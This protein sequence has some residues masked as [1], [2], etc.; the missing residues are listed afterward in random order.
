MGCS[1]VQ[2]GVMGCNGMQRGAAGCSGVQRGAVGCSS[3]PPT[4]RKPAC[5]RS[6]HSPSRAAPPA[7]C[8]AHP[9]QVAAP[10]PAPNRSV[11]VPVPVPVPPRPERGRPSPPVLTHG[12]GLA[13]APLPPAG[14]CCGRPAIPAIPAIPVIP[15]IPAEPA[16]PAGLTDV[17]GRAE[18]GLPQSR[19]QLG[20]PGRGEPTGTGTA[21]GSGHWHPSPDPTGPCKTARAS[22]SPLVMPSREGM[23][24]LAAWECGPYIPAAL[25]PP[26]A[27]S[28]LK[29]CQI[30]LGKVAYFTKR[31]DSAL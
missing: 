11:S 30:L 21:S 10:P 1:G 6:G 28:R 12:P 23:D 4:P 14:L 31:I 9:A 16:R 18:P 20:A 13:V 15:A 7:C 8:I 25:S 26:T 5:T 27:D 17:C 29:T 22:V 2:W 3:R 24:A 19:R